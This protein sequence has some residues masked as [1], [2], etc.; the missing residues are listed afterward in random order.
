MIGFISTLVTSSLSHTEIQCYRRFAHF[1]IT[2]VHALGFRVSTG[3][4][5]ATDLNQEISTSN[6]YGAFLLFLLQSL[7][8]L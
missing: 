5:L 1:A 2:V 6:H 8:N 7:W 3:H 4:L